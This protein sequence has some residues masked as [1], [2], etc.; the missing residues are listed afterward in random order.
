MNQLPAQKCLISPNPTFVQRD[1]NKSLLL[2][3]LDGVDIVFVASLKKRIKHSD[4]DVCTQ[5]FK[6][7]L[8][9]HLQRP[10]EGTEVSALALC[11][12][13]YFIDLS[14]TP[15]TDVS[16]LADCRYLRYLR[17]LRSLDLS[18]TKVSDVSALRMCL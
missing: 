12:K 14:E 1:L 15:V 13:L 7:Q 10:I 8:L 4:A 3:R 6:K 16:A 17:Y 9:S 5:T 11:R 18:G 2:A